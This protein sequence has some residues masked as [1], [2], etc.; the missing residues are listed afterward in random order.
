[1]LNNRSPLA[2]FRSFVMSY[3]RY[4]AIAFAIGFAA[5]I[6]YVIYMANTSGHLIF[7]DWIRQM[8]YGDKVGHFILFG[9]LTFAFNLASQFKAMSIK[10]VKLYYGSIVVS[11][12]VIIE[13]VSQAFIPT[14]TFDWLDLMADACGIGLFTIA[15]VYTARKLAPPTSPAHKTEN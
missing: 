4:L 15:S 10:N 12:F 8:P 7:F 5:F 13:E 2:F 14:R 3:F 11:M 1:M 6:M 9:I